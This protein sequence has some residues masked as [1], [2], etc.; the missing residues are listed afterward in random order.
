MSSLQQQSIKPQLPRKPATIF[1]FKTMTCVLVSHTGGLTR[2]RASRRDL[3]ACRRLTS[4]AHS[5]LWLSGS[6]VSGLSVCW[7]S[8]PGSEGKRQAD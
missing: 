2:P 5:L 3:V 6:V 4:R 7:V 8:A 1:I